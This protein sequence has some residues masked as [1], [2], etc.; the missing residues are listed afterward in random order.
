MPARAW[1]KLM[2]FV[3]SALAH[4]WINQDILGGR[5]EGSQNVSCRYMQNIKK[6]KI[7]YLKKINYETTSN[8]FFPHSRKTIQTFI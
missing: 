6:D 3:A 8:T 4:T 7:F 2:K 1:A 5:G